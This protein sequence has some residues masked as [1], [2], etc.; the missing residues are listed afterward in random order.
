MVSPP[1]SHIVLG[2]ANMARA[3]GHLQAWANS[4]NCRAS[5]HS[6]DH[7]QEDE[8]DRKTR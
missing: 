2:T 1:L 4:G 8:M 3:A 5:D 7:A 6:S